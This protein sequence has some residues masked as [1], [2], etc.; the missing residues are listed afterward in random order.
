MYE[1]DILSQ[2]GALLDAASVPATIVNWAGDDIITAEEYLNYLGELTGVA[3]RF[4]YDNA[5]SGYM[6]PDSTRR[7]SITGPSL[8]WQ[9]AMREML[10]ARRPERLLTADRPN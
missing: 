8:N 10:M 3:P 1:G 4:D 7:R 9:T 5:T 2:A 6:L